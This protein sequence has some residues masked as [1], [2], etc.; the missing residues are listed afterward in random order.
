MNFTEINREIALEHKRLD[1]RRGWRFLYT[2]ARTLAPET[3]IAFVALNPGGGEYERP[4]PSEER[5]NAYRIEVDDWQ[6]HGQG[7]RG[8]QIQVRLLYDALAERDGSTAEE[9]M[10][11]QTLALNF[12]PFRSRSWKELASPKESIEFSQWMWPRVLEKVEP[13][14]IICLGGVSMRY[15]GRVLLRERKAELTRREAHPVGWGPVKYAVARY[16]TPRGE[17]TMVGIPHL[18]RFRIFG[19]AKSEHA[20]TAIVDTISAALATS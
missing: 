11:E 3:R 10:D 6:A 17:V 7:G 8:L 5:G 9:M 20:T 18:S 12:C 19:R 4:K 13:S 16:A 15:L 1:H 2:P 14:V